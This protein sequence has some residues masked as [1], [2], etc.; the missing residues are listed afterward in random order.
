MVKEFFKHKIDSWLLPIMPLSIIKKSLQLN[1]II[2]YY[3]MV[4]DDEILH[5]KHLYEYKNVDQFRNDIEFLL[6][7]FSPINLNDVLDYLKTGNSFPNNAF[8]LTFDDG[9][10][11]MH[12]VVAPFLKKKGVPAIFFCNSAFIDNKN[13]CFQHKASIL[14]EHLQKNRNPNL[15]HKIKG[16]L[17][18]NK[19]DS[20]NIKAA[21][22]SATY[23]Q[24]DI[25]D[26]IGQLLGIDFNEYLSKHKPYLTIEQIETLIKDGFSIGA[27]SIDHPLYSVLELDDQLYQTVESLKFIK[28]KFSLEY[29]A[30]AFPHS[31]KDVS[32]K[33]Y[34]ELYRT[35]LVDIS[36]GTSGMIEDSFP[37][38]LQRFSLEKP[39][40]PA[41]KIIAF[42]AI[43]SLYRSA[44]G[45]GRIVRTQLPPPLLGDD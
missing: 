4:S 27:H 38:N 12:D 14:I 40:M 33:F 45:R 18:K 44:T 31:D 43:R 11:E 16:I 30:F 22:L 42:Q 39:L 28:D 26:Q 8:L 3:H 41:K 17:K 9:F 20:P 13:L 7:N 5:V 34:Q 23:K 19:I 6:K 35:D 25:A 36:F 1:P 10:R 37:K 15:E 21:I 32:M 24:K 29:G 2:P